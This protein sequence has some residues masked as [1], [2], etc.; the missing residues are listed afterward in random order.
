[1]AI[2]DNSL[3][4][5]APASVT[6]PEGATTATFNVSTT[7]VGANT[8]ATLTGSYN[9]VSRAG[10]L[11]IT[12]TAPPPPPSG[13][14][15]TVQATGRSGEGLVSSPAGVNAKV[16]TISSAGFAANTVVTLSAAN[17]RDVIWS[18]SCSSG[19]KKA[20]S[21]TFTIKANSSVTANVQ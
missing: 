7:P 15:L 10:T 8:T 16:G 2:L 21:C 4:A 9:G 3:V 12:A 1:V 14:T 13:L 18:G 6:V 5:S 11:T 20:K 19:G 17:N